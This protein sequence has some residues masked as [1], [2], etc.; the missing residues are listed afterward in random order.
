MISDLELWACAAQ[1]LKQHGAF[2]NAHIAERVTSLAKAGDARGVATWR[3]IAD[4][5]DQLNDKSGE[6]SA[7][8]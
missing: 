5:I 3:A 6:G 7:R 2:A 4:R 1:V 8:H